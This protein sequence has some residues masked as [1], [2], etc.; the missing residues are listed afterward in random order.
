M[1]KFRRFQ[2]LIPTDQQIQKGFPVG[3]HDGVH[4][5]IELYSGFELFGHYETWANGYRVSDGAIQ[6]EAEYL[7]TAIDTYFKARAGEL[8]PWQFKRLA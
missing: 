5:T 3:M 1:K 4:L 2:D 8:Q 7:D 6:V